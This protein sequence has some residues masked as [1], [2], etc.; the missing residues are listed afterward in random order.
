MYLYKRKIPNQQLC[1]EKAALARVIKSKD[2]TYK[3]STCK[4]RLF[5][6]QQAA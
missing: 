2:I 1:K 6:L 3:V 4:P 5:I